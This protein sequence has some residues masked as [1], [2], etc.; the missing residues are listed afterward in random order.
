MGET[1]TAIALLS[2]FGGQWS[3]VWMGSAK[4]TLTVSFFFLGVPYAL[5]EG[6]TR[7]GPIGIGQPMSLCRVNLLQAMKLGFLEMGEN[8]RMLLGCG[9]T[10]LLSARAI[11]LSSSPLS[12]LSPCSNAPL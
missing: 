5:G 1:G 6:W 11:I 2:S 10:L 8:S 7:S 9:L 12:L 3:P 4:G